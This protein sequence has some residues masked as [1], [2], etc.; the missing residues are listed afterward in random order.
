MTTWILTLCILET[1]Q[2]P[3]QYLTKVAREVVLGLKTTFRVFGQRN[4]SLSSLS[5]TLTKMM[6]MLGIK[7]KITYKY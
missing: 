2:N 4:F 5:S 1:D 7:A 6:I 3:L